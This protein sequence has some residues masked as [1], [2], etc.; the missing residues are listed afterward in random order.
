MD[1]ISVIDVKLNEIANKIKKESKNIKTA[2]KQCE[3]VS[4]ELTKN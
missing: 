2:Q 1:S 3:Q 4:K